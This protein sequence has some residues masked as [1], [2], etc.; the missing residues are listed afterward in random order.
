MIALEEGREAS[1]VRARRGR[2]SARRP[3]AAVAGHIGGLD[4]VRAFAVL[5]VIVFHLW[6][7]RV[8]GGFLGVDVFF[9]ISGFLITTL[10]LREGNRSGRID[11]IGFWIRRARRLLPAL[12]LVVVTSIVVAWLVSRGLLVGADR[13]TVGALTF[14]SNWLEISAG[15]DYFD[16]TRRPC[17]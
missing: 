2:P 5:A 10:L 17:S 11:L 7:R 12:V 4:G 13:Q 3:S 6:P 9:V 8:P 16:A 14:S 15:S 1:D